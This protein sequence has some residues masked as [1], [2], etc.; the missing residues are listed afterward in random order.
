ML[1]WAIR[2]C[3]TRSAEVLAITNEIHVACGLWLA[4]AIYIMHMQWLQY[5]YIMH[6][7]TYEIIIVQYKYSIEPRLYKTVMTDNS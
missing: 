4:I 7:C 2:I 6:A 5:S 3:S 1:G